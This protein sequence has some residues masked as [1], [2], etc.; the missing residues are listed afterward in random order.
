MNRNEKVGSFL[1]G[2][3]LFAA[4][5]YFIY[6]SWKS[7]PLGAGTYA[8]DM[9]PLDDYNYDEEDTMTEE[10]PVAAPAPEAAK[11]PAETPAPAP[12]KK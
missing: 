3:A 12:V 6:T 9:A 4:L 10:A 1:L 8:E 7:A 5:G 2:A 11:A